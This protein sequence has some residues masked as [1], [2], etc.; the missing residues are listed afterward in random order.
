MSPYVADIEDA[1]YASYADNALID[2]CG[3]VLSPVEIGKRVIHIPAVPANVTNVPRHLL[4]HLITDVRRMHIPT[5]AGISLASCVGRMIRQGY[6]HRN[7]AHAATWRRIYSQIGPQAATSP[8]Q[9][10]AVVTGLSGV[11]KSTAIERALQ[12]YRQ[13]VTHRS[14]PGLSGEVRQL[15]WLKVDVPAS[16]KTTDLVESLARATDD[17]LGANFTNDLFGGRKLQGAT[18]AHRW[19]QKVSCNFPGLLVLDEIQNLFKIEQ[20]AVRQSASRRTGAQRPELRIADDEALKLLLTL[21]NHSK[22][23]MLFCSTPD[24]LNALTTRWSTAQR[25]T[26]GGMHRIPHAEAADDDFFR[27]MLFPQLCRYQVLPKKLPASDELRQ[28]LFELSGGILRIC[29]SLWGHAHT[30]AIEL[31]AEGLAFEHFRHAAANTLAPVQP[32]VRALLSNDPRAQQLYEDM[33]SHP[34]L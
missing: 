28:L 14:L 7:P 13:V 16:G 18:L 31:G 32:A 21:S 1:Q 20:K 26:T 3:P 25:M 19:L 2:A 34:S 33:I 27:K 5:G 17:A 10:G 23:P 22:I 9:L 6:V 24:G 12:L 4:D 15:I 8:I 30:R 29:M 11:G